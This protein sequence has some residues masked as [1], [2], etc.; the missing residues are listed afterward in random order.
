[1]PLIAFAIEVALLCLAAFTL[2]SYPKGAGAPA[3]A[4]SVLVVFAWPLHLCNGWRSQT[5][6]IGVVLSFLWTPAIALGIV[7]VYMLLKGQNTEQNLGSD[8]E[9]SAPQD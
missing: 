6:W 8:A 1:M 3:W 4:D 7:K 9:S 5:I 2:M